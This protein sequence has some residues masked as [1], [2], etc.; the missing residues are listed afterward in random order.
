MSK[1]GFKESTIG[2]SVREPKEIAERTNL[3]GP[4]QVKEHLANANVGENWKSKLHFLE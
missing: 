3:L 4:E 1:Q 2:S